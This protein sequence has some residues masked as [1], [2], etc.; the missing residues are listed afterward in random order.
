MQSVLDFFMTD[1]R[2]CDSLWAKAEG[3][4]E[5]KSEGAKAAFEA[6]SAAMRRHF[7]M[8]E[9]I[10]FPAIEE[11]TGMVNQGPTA[12]MRSEHEQMRGVLDQMEQALEEGDLQAALDQGDTLLMLIQ[13]HNIK[14]EG[15]LYPM[16]DQVLGEGWEVLASKLK[17]FES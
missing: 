2:G 10:L 3:A 17:H 13:Q 8:E 7:A 16:A 4:L 15:V 12:V 6:F 5:K 9:E 14:E 1:H 11:R